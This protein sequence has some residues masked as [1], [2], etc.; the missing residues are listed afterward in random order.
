VETATVAAVERVNAAALNEHDVDAV[1][2]AM[3]GDC[4][5]ENTWPPPDGVRFVG[6][7]AVRTFW[8]NMLHDSPDARFETEELVVAGDR[9]VV[10]WRYTYTG[11]DGSAHHLSGIDLFRVQGGLIAEK[12]A[13]VK[14]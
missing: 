10:R 5:F 11:D 1:M 3:T 6:Q 8:A 9:C 2:A 13:Y 14:G 4:V 12:L 7:E